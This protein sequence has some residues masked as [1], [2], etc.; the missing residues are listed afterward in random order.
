MRARWFRFRRP[1]RSLCGGGAAARSTAGRPACCQLAGVCGSAG[2]RRCWPVACLSHSARGCGVCCLLL[3]GWAG[4]W[5]GGAGLT[6]HL[7]PPGV[8]RLPPACR[9]LMR[10]LDSGAQPA[11]AQYAIHNHHN[12]GHLLGGT[13]YQS[14][15]QGRGR[16]TWNCLAS[17]SGFGWA[18]VGD[19]LVW[20]SGVCT[21][22]TTLHT[23]HVAQ[24]S[25]SVGCPAVCCLVFCLLVAAMEHTME[26]MVEARLVRL[27]ARLREAAVKGQGQVFY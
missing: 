7:T 6:M 22:C 14:G 20:V 15:P 9:L 16:V 11:L 3:R 2:W 21:W 1:P 13:S 19:V 5:A 4:G 23:A 25:L 10:A 8:C 12:H 27:E 26:H 18:S 17:G 24:I